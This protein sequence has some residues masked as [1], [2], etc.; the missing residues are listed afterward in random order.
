MGLSL[1]SNGKCD[2]PNPDPKKFTI[3][4]ST[5]F[6]DKRSIFVLEVN[7]AGCTALD[8]MK[9]VVYESG[10]DEFLAFL[11]N[12]ELDPHFLDPWDSRLSPI[13]RFPATP[14][15]IDDALKFADWKSKQER[16]DG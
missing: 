5:Q 14:E 2:P 7:Y 12:G 11:R 10:L 6:E 3:T 16:V 15:G 9:I 1:F 4:A 13:A 8:G